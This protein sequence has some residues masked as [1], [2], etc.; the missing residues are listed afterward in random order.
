M[1]RRNKPYRALFAL[2]AGAVHHEGHS[3]RVISSRFTARIA[4]DTLS[5][6]AIRATG[7]AG[8]GRPTMLKKVLTWGLLAFLVFFV[9]SKPANAAI[10]FKQ[11]GNGLMDIGEG[12]GEFF[13]NLVS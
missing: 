9:V 7:F 1:K 2:L 5:F 4:T 11:L 3:A 8:R 6:V 12:V 10:V 13:T